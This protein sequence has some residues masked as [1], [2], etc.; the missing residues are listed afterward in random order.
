MDE[1]YKGLFQE[2]LAHPLVGPYLKEKG[3][4]A[5]SEIKDLPTRCGEAAAFILG[6]GHQGA[7]AVLDETTGEVTL[8]EFAAPTGNGG[9]VELREL[10]SDAGDIV[11][12]AGGPRFT[13]TAGNPKSECV[14]LCMR[15]N[16]CSTYDAVCWA[17]WYAGC[18][19]GCAQYAN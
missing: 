18:I 11:D 13:G 7:A 14:A 15:D 6:E 2:L 4:V 19:S 10:G 3:W 17:A 8:V 1:R 16:D 5:P 12:T 9:R